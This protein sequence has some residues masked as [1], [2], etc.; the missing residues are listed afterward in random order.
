MSAPERRRLDELIAEAQRMLAICNACR[1][2]EGYCAVFPGARA[3]ARVR[4]GRRALPREPLPQLRRVPVRVPVRA[5]ARVPA[6]LPARARAGARARPTASTR[7]PRSS[8]RA[9]ERNGAGREPRHR[10]WPRAVPRCSPPGTRI[11]RASSRAWS[12]AQGS[13]Y[14]V[15]PHGVM[16]G[17]F[18]AVFAFV[19]LAFAMS[20]ARFWPD[21]GE[22]TL[23]FVQAPPLSAARRGT[24][25]ASS[26][27]TAAATAAPIRTSSPSFARR[28]FHHFTFYGFMLCFAATVR[29]DDLPLRVRLEGAVSAL[30]PAGAARHRSAASGCSSGPRDCS[31]C[32]RAARSGARRS[33]RRRAWTWASW[34]CCS[35]RASPGLAL[36]VAARDARHGRAA[37]GAPG[38]GAGALPHAALRQVR[39]SIPNPWDAGSA[40][41]LQGP[42]LPGARHHQLGPCL[43][44]RAR[45]R[46]PAAR[47][48]AGAPARHGRGDRPAGQRRLRERLRDRRRRA[49]PRTCAWRSRPAWPGCRSRTRPATPLAPCSTSRW[50]WRA[51]ARPRAAPSTLP[52]A[53]PCWSAGPRTS[54]SADPT[55]TTPS[56]ACRPTPQAGADCL[57]A[58]GIRTREQI[59]AVV[60]AVAPKPVNLLIGST[61]ELTLAD[62]AA[63]GVRRVSVG[64]AMARA[65]WGGFMR[66]RTRSPN[67]AL[68]RLR[69]CCVGRRATRA[70]RGP[71][72]AQLMM[73]C[74]ASGA[75]CRI[76]STVP[77]ARLRTQPASACACAASRRL[78]RKP[79]PCTRPR[80]TSRRV[81]ASLI[82]AHPAARLLARR[83]RASSPRCAAPSRRAWAAWRRASSARS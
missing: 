76:A 41:Y 11:R 61:S 34:C 78:K 67:R 73:P 77:S 46:R 69:G 6:Q 12:D 52:A 14:A 43:V 62:V 70:P 60:A 39:A 38:R 31:G 68:R 79:T 16:A 8:A 53:T 81:T 24:R 50:R 59:A 15:L 75:P 7:G 49:W 22:E 19:L 64:G 1:Y 82:A 2:C 3:P 40:R 28:T 55:S 17:V 63:L 32:R 71:R 36:L 83:P 26:T 56:P 54:S 27:S 65:A 25:P 35:S 21:M 9:F 4:R 58:P 30:Q 10:G 57:Y 66:A 20:F 42:G 44:A 29:G 18:G 47:R 51:C 13:F 45:R 72:W 5:A 37:R 23:E 74:T 33:E 48:G 80:I